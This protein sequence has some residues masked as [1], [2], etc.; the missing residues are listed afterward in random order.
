MSDALESQGFKF[1]IGDASSPIDYTKVS[2]VTN[3]TGLDGEA[4]EIDVTHLESTAKEYLMGLQD[5]GNFSLD[6][7]YLPNDAGQIAMRAAKASRAIQN[8]KAE[9]SDG[10]VITFQGFV[11][12]NPISGGVD[13]KLDGSFNIRV[14]GNVTIDNTP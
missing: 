3:F 5:F 11:K 1:Y 12:S 7:N 14:S 13:A 4:S 6:V 2:E 10:T 9:L 8:F